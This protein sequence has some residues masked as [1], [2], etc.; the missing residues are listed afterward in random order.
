[1]NP[2]MVSVRKSYVKSKYGQMHLRIATP[3]QTDARPLLCIHLSP[4]SGAV[5]K[6]FMKEIG[7]DRLTIA[8]DNPGYGMSDGPNIPPD[9][10][11]F[12]EA[13]S[14]LLETLE[15]TDVDV[16]GYGTG[17]KISFELALRRPDAV[18]HL[19][20]ISAP[21]YTEEEA[22]Y[23]QETLGADIEPEADGSHLVKL[24]K[25]VGGFPT[26]EQ[27]MQI[28]PEHIRACDRK[29]WGP[30][31]AFAYRYEDKIGELQPPLMVLNIDNEIREPTARIAPHIN[32]GKYIELFKWKHGFLDN[33][34][35]EAAEI[36]RNFLDAPS[37]G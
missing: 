17:S 25:Q 34:P 21:V 14:R 3:M 16:M 22:A 37:R 31:A 1:M 29:P 23:M 26:L 28:Y 30:R 11:V 36:I 4:L 9:I 12:A 5:Y 32:N 19:I 35:A 18:K 24:W 15:L 8:P 7:K 27:R 6:R 20:L 2:P 33:H 10:G 13:M